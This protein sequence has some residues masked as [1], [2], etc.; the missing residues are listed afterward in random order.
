[1][2]CPKCGSYQVGVID[3]KPKPSGIRRRRKCQD[4]GYRFTTMEVNM[5]W[6][7]E[8]R[9]EACPWNKR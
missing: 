5:E 9:C 1:M 3:T 6:L 4:C 8:K 7:I 2:N